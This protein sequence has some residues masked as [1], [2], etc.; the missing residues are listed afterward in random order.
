MDV[1]IYFYDVLPVALDELED[2]LDSGFSGIGEVTG[3]GTGEA[4]SNVDL[5]VTDSVPESQVIQIVRRT[6][7]EFGIATKTTVVID[8]KRVQLLP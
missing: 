8:G 4:G 5:E 2:A 7:S 1:F 3:T 6:L